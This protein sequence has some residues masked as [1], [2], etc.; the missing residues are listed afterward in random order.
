MP[1]IQNSEIVSYRC[2]FFFY[3]SNLSSHI[4][5]RVELLSNLLISR[6][7]FDRGGGGGGLGGALAR[8]GAAEEE[9]VTKKKVVIRV[10]V[11]M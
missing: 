4:F 5:L 7:F 9:W 2:V 3:A 11:T 8:R 1:S 10:V 6:C